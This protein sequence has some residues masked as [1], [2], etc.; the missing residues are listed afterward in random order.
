ML[1]KRIY[2]VVCWLAVL[3]LWG[4]AASVYLS[5]ATWGRWLALFDLGFPFCVA[6][7]VV[8]GAI[9]AV[10]RTRAAFIPLVGLI[11]CCGS[12]RD[13]C[14]INLSS[15]PPKQGIKVITYNTLNYG[16]WQTDEHGYFEVI[17]FLLRERPQIACLQETTYKKAE[18][19]EQMIAQLKRFGY[20]YAE[21]LINR[22][23]LA[24]ISR[25][26]IARQELV[27]DGGGNSGAAYYLTPR[28]GDTL[29]VVNVH[30]QSMQL[31]N[32]ERSGYHQMV[33]NPE[34]VE[35]IK[36]KR[37]LLSKI[38]TA[39]IARAH[40][41]DTLAAFIDRHK[42]DKLLVM[43]DFNDTP[44]SYAHQKVCSRLTDVYRT[45][46]NGIGRSFHQDAI[47]VRIDHM[48]CSE[49]FK[50]YAARV[51]N[52]VPFSDH[53]PLVCYFVPKKGQ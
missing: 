13:Y 15:P 49:Q 48:F 34:D 20:S 2:S 32:E 12:L 17:N 16:N 31:T 37:R 22:A 25:W 41:A 1:I 46:G 5:P 28:R 24:I 42:A 51:M 36:G 18:M 50:P 30:M 9:G 10:C 33:R 23:P 38:A 6:L 19:R 47:Y 4:C 52:E 44:I 45:T 11:G 26:P 14:P 40:Q 7:V 3:L 35:L 39:G 29:I 8:L 27:F 43:G 21:T 53:Y